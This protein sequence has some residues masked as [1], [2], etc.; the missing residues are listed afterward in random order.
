MY[1]LENIDSIN[2]KFEN[3]IHTLENEDLFEKTNRIDNILN[4]DILTGNEALGM[5]SLNKLSSIVKIKEKN[6]FCH[7][8]IMLGSN[9]YLNVANNPKVKKASK[10]AL[11]KFGIRKKDSKILQL[12]RCNRF[13]I[14]IWN[15][16]WSDIGIM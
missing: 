8:V 15:K 7:D 1:T 2:I 13:S 3:F 4:S 10:E 14:R 12:R 6:G 16:C 11:E 5:M 9:S